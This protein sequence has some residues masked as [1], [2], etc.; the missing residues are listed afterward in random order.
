MD[1]ETNAF[2]QPVGLPVALDL[3]RPPPPHV[4]LDGRHVRLVP[5]APEHADGFFACFTDPAGWTYL[6]EDRGFAD[7]ADARAWTEAHA[8][9]RDPLFYTVLREG[10]PVGFCSYLRITPVHGVIEIGFIHFSPAIQGTPA[11]TEVQYLMMSHVFDD[12]GY[13]RYEWKCDSLN[14]PS[15]KAAARLGF[16]YE[17]TFRQAQVTKGRNRDTAWYSILDSEW[18][19]LRDRFRAWL[20]PS[21]FDAEGQ[22]IRR[23]EECG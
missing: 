22:Q 6:G 5:M 14:A 7:L 13:R 16:T 17:G 8:A 20:D 15:R 9:S 19:A 10:V 1:I 12:L 2:G 11:A 3:P 21:N 18:P 4:P 23:L